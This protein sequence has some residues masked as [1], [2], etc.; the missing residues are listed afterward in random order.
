[1]AKSLATPSCKRRARCGGIHD[2]SRPLHQENPGTPRPIWWFSA[3]CPTKCCAFTHGFAI[4]ASFEGAEGFVRL[5]LV[6]SISR[7]V[8]LP[9]PLKQMHGERGA[10]I[11][12]D[13]ALGI[14]TAPDHVVQRQQIAPQP[15]TAIDVHLG[16]GEA[17]DVRNQVPQYR[18]G[19][20]AE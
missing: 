19:S 14:E 17:Y 16:P 15:A 12:S 18:A 13:Y 2:A 5:G 9:N 6:R 1:L 20:E 7:F 8:Q 11:Q 10:S 4:T 3:S